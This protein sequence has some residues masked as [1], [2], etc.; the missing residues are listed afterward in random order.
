MCATKKLHVSLYKMHKL[1]TNSQI[2]RVHGSY[3]LCSLRSKFN[4]MKP[5]LC[6]TAWR[7]PASRTWLLTSFV[8][9]GFL[10]QVRWVLTQRNITGHYLPL[11]LPKM[12]AAIKALKLCAAGHLNPP[13]DHPSPVKLLFSRR[14]TAHFFTRRVKTVRFLP[15]RAWAVLC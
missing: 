10:L 4:T 2:I 14:W 11:P 15:P 5:S 13:P 7:K 3:G 1:A 8:S 12:V 6:E 9:R